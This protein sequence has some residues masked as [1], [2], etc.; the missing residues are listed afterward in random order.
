MQ[1]LLPLSSKCPNI[2]FF[3]M[4]RRP[5]RSTLFPYTTLFRSN[6]DRAQHFPGILEITAGAPL[7]R[8]NLRSARKARASHQRPIR[9]ADLDRMS[10]RGLVQVRSIEIDSG[11]YVVRTM[12][13]PSKQCKVSA[14]LQSAG[15]LQHAFKV[16]PLWAGWSEHV[17]L[18]TL[19][20]AAEM[21]G[22]RGYSDFKESAVERNLVS[23]RYQVPVRVQI[24]RR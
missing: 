24:R 11:L 19:G 21:I 16:I 10:N 1:T 8:G 4:I 18:R 2:F 23:S 12:P 20:D 5:P 6:G 7:R 22:I 9:L 14:A 13:L 17:C 3:L 15:V